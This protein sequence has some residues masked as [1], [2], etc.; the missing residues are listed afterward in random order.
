MVWTERPYVY[1]YVGAVIPD[2]YILSPFNP[3][4]LYALLQD[5]LK[6]LLLGEGNRLLGLKS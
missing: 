4:T 3:I 5:L 1:I 2:L 6:Y